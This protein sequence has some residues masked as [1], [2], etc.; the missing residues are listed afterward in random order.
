MVRELVADVIAQGMRATVKPEIRETVEAV[1]Y[2]LSGGREPIER[3]GNRVTMVL[4]EDL[5]Y[6]VTGDDDG[7]GMSLTQSIRR[8]QA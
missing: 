8:A 2:L 7:S 4:S 1:K 5:L 3:K 6:K